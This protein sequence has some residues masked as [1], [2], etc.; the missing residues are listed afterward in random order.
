MISNHTDSVFLSLLPQ[1]R[2]TLIRIRFSPNRGITARPT[3][4][5]EEY[6]NVERVRQCWQ[7]SVYYTVLTAFHSSCRAT[8]VFERSHATLSCMPFTGYASMSTL[9]YKLLYV[10]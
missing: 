8:L 10:H 4:A 6:G 7:K 1:I 2:K 3:S 5:Y 9:L